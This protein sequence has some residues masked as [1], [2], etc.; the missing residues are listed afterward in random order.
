VQGAVDML[1]ARRPCTCFHAKKKNP[2]KYQASS[3]F[4]T[5]Q[6]LS[7]LLLPFS[8]SI[9]PLPILHPFPLLWSRITPAPHADDGCARQGLQECL[10]LRPFL[11]LRGSQGLVGKLP[12][13]CPVSSLFIGKLHSSVW[14]P[15][16]NE[17]KKL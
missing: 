10:A 2:P 6:H 4:S 11:P 14:L 5:L 17:Y 1:Y 3:L 15:E 12:A 16:K 8:L 7:A 9:L 13:A